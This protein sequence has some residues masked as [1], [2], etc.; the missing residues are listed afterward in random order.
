MA[1]ERWKAAL[2]RE[3]TLRAKVEKRCEDLHQ[4]LAPQIRILLFT[5]DLSQKLFEF[6][7]LKN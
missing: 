5:S 4:V 1:V 2:T 6:V 3:E 7:F